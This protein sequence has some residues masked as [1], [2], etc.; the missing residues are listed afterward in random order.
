VQGQGLAQVA[1]Q[2]EK[3]AGTLKKLINEQLATNFA[4]KARTAADASRE[5]E[6]SLD[7]VLAQI[8]KGE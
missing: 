2:I 5:P 1:E 4:R 3:K 8:D 7:E 6:L